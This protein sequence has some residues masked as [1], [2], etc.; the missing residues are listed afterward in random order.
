M[1]EFF[2]I[3]EKP[4]ADDVVQELSV[5][6]YGF[7]FK[8]VTKKVVKGRGKK[9]HTDYKTYYICVDVNVPDSLKKKEFQ[10]PETFIKIHRAMTY[11]G[12]AIRE[13]FH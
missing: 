13:Q 6:R 5:E 12:N 11:R 4:L 7:H 9:K 2:E 1:T 3:P 10:S 8:K